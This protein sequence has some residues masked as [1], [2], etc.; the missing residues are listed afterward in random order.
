MPVAVGWVV[1]YG[2]VALHVVTMGAWIGGTAVG[3]EACCIGVLFFPFVH[4]DVGYGLT[5]KAVKAVHA[6][7]GDGDAFEGGNAFLDLG[8][9]VGEGHG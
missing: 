6:V 4:V 5:E 7:N 9:E 3:I 8:C 2:V 1:F